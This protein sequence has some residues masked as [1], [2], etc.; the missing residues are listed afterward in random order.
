[1]EKLW[2]LLQ[3]QATRIA[4]KS[5][6]SD[7]CRSRLGQFYSDPSRGAWWNDSIPANEIVFAPICQSRQKS[8]VVIAY[9]AP[10]PSPSRPFPHVAKIMTPSFTSRHPAASTR[11]FFLSLI[12]C[13]STS[14]CFFPSQ[15]RVAQ[16]T[17]GAASK[18]A[19]IKTVRKKIARVL[20]VYHQSQ[21]KRVRGSRN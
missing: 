1:M 5:L 18:L 19:K 12:F 15:L 9:A 11:F 3:R 7:V 10:L 6:S 2:R 4:G 21:K 14:F 17:G 16:V 8:M 13:R 20:T